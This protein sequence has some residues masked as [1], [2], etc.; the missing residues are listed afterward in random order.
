MLLEGAVRAVRTRHGRELVVHRAGPGATLGEIPL[1]DGGGYPATL[2]A[3]RDCVFLVLEREL[4]LDIMG[5]DPGLAWRML[6]T[7]AAELGTVREVVARTLADL[8]RSG[9]LER[10]GRARYRVVDARGLRRLA[11]LPESET[12]RG[13]SVPMPP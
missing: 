6:E 11:G 1:F 13:E 7:L 4:L 5:R 10:A 8:V 12:S 2:I 3:D 9:L